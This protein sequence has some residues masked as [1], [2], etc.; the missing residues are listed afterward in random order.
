VNKD[1]TTEA[2]RE[3]S[4]PDGKVPPLWPSAATGEVR[5][6]PQRFDL[7]CR[8]RREPAPS[9]PPPFARTL[10]G[11]E[12]PFFFFGFAYGQAAASIVRPLRASVSLW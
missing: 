2:E 5:R 1:F 4:P 9:Y 3:V 6:G 12:P 11:E 7:A 10:T 8:L